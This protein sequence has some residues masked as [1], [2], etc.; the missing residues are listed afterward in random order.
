MLCDRRS[1]RGEVPALQLVSADGES[2]TA[3]PQGLLKTFET[4]LK[5]QQ[6]VQ[7]WAAFSQDLKEPEYSMF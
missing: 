2:E 4:K 1:G 7:G 6:S 3:S 5:V